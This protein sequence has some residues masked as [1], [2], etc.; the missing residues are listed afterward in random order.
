MI[1]LHLHTNHSDG[2]DTV[3]EL[4][5]KANDLRLKVISI[6][7]HDSVGAYYE[8]EDTPSLRKKF[9]GDI[10]I[11]SEIK[12]YFEDVNI[13]I[14]AYGIDYKKIDI[15]KE[16]R[17]KVQIDILKHFRKVARALNLK[18]N[19][20]IEI[21]LTDPHKQ[22]ASALFGEDILKY[23]E[24]KEII[25]LLGGINKDTFYRE[26]ESNENSPFYYN[27]SIY[28]DSAQTVI[29]KIHQSGGLA[30]LAHGFIYPFKNKRET[31]EKILKTTSI[32]GLECIYP[33][34]S[35]EEMKYIVE[36]CKK[37]KKYMS[38][39]SDYHGDIKATTFMATGINNN[40]LVKEDLIK[41]WKNKVRKI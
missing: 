5:K 17:K 6:T 1:D 8:I 21:D 23:E 24:N 26:H 13:E 25:K 39:G 34:F 37:Y 11:G 28:Y 38:G 18:F 32:D 29:D 36:L 7:D 2:S 9:D 15:K 19:E 30:F 16:D 4:L 27:T 10:I 35:R 33:L 3:E 14:L 31:I 20:N 41:D 40:I 12:S 22:F